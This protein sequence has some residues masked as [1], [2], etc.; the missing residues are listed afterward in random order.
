MSATW[1]PRWIILFNKIYAFGYLLMTSLNFQAIANPAIMIAP[2]FI[3]LHGFRGPTFGTT[4]LGP[5]GREEM[6]VTPITF[7]LQE[8]P[9]YT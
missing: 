7:W 4:R 9:Y 3:E 6:C 1:K 2:K 5:S 8:Y